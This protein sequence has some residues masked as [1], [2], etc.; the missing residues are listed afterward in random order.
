MG[1]HIS[2][3]SMTVVS[4]AKSGEDLCCHLLNAVCTS[5]WHN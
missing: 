2:I 1:V 5:N 4:T 3:I